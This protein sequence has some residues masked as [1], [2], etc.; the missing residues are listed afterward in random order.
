M[1]IRTADRAGVF[2]QA[3]VYAIAGYPEHML[4]LDIEA[5]EIAGESDVCKP[6]SATEP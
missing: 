6:C 1:P 4:Q 5:D 3:V 2:D